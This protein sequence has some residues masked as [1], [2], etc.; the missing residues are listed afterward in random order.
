MIEFEPLKIAEL[1]GPLV[2]FVVGM[3]QIG[4]IWRGIAQMRRASENRDQQHEENMTALRALIG[5]QHEEN[6]TALRALI[7]RTAPKGTE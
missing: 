6:M 3:G 4:M 7:E 5:Q 1:I 2:T